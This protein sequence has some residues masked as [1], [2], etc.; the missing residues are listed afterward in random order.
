MKIRGVAVNNRKKSFEVRAGRRTLPFPFAKAAPE[1]STAD[2]VSRAFVDRELGGEAFSFVLAS[3][4]EGTVHIEEVLEYNQDPAWVRERLLYTLTLEA[5][6]RLAESPLSK[7]EIVRRL[8]TSASQ[9]YRIVDQ[10]NYRKSV[11]QVLGLL[12]VLDCEVEVIVRTK[13]A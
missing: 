1:P 9:F 6:R 8:G 13:S 12:H 7:R 10:R 2:P 4:R 11:D 3:G 5:Q